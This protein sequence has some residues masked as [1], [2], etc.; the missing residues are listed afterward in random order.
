MSIMTFYD[1]FVW[2][3]RWVCAKRKG[4]SAT[5]KHSLNETSE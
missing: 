2:L 3:V 1:G 5:R 4:L